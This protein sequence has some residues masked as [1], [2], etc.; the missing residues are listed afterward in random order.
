ME[1]F[2][3]GRATVILIDVN[4]DETLVC[5]LCR[6]PFRSLETAWLMSPPGGGE[7]RWTHKPC[8][9][10]AADVVFGHQAY[11]L[12]RGDFAMKSLVQKLW[13]RTI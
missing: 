8:I 9:D 11:R 12:R 7:A 1:S 3:H 13:L 6:R 10:G 4:D 5:S 2:E